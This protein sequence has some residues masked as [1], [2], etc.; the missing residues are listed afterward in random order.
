MSALRV[1]A[2][3]LVAA[4]LASCR[5][6]PTRTVVGPGADAPWAQQRAALDKLDR[7]ALD[8]RVAVAANGQGFSASLR[9]TQAADRTQFSLEGPLGIGGLRVE[10][11]GG[12]LEVA[13]SRGEKLD[14]PEARAELER[15]LGFAL[16]LEELRWWLLGIPAPGE[17][18]VNAAD[19]GE[20]RD[21]T[22]NGWRVSINSRAPGIGFSLPQRLTAQHIEGPGPGESNRSGARIKLLAERWE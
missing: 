1:A 13:T 5:T 7:Y 22:Q 16:P 4:V 2:C 10:A 12:R 11:E 19:T 17:S 18:T 9:Y 21:F 15:R 20:I 6:V 8:G 3:V 14:G